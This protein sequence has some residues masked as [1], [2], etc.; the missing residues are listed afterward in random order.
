MIVDKATEYILLL[1]LLAT[2]VIVYLLVG[3]YRKTSVVNRTA[4]LLLSALL[5]FVAYIGTC[6]YAVPALA[7]FK[8]LQFT[9]TDA[10]I[11]NLII[12]AVCLG[13]WFFAARF[14]LAV[15]RRSSYS[16]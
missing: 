7:D 3:K 6:G 14:F 2:P 9:F 16:R 12:W 5:A 1:S 8:N 11:H 4:H 10:F 13:G 15:F